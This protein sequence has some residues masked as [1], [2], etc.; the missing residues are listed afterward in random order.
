MNAGTCLERVNVP[1]SLILKETETY[2]TTD[3][4]HVDLQSC[5]SHWIYAICVVCSLKS[6]N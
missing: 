4:Y 5:L 6:M 3:K 2:Y 1:K